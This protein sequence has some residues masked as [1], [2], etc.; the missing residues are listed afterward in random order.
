MPQ[1]VIP[2]DVPADV[3]V[4][5][6]VSDNERFV[7]PEP[8]IVD[9]APRA[10]HVAKRSATR[11]LFVGAVAA[12]ALFAAAFG[13]SLWGHRT[14][15]ADAAARTPPAPLIPKV[16][17]AAARKA[18]DSAV[19]TPRSISTD[20]TATTA[21]TF[22]DAAAPIPSAPR[23]Q[24]KATAA[25]AS[26]AANRAASTAPPVSRTRPL[27]HCRPESPPLQARGSDGRRSRKLRRTRLRSVATANP[28]TR[29]PRTS[30][31]S[32]SPA[33]GDGTGAAS[34][35]HPA[36]TVG[37][38]GRSS[39]LAPRPADPPPRSSRPSLRSLAEH[40]ERWRGGRPTT[41]SRPCSRR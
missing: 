20:A 18:A 15:P 3:V 17:V 14:A 19:S 39:V 24:P 35:S 21:L 40:F 36:P 33:D 29:P 6:V 32:V 30:R 1:A 41:G 27:P 12:V 23:I 8:V 13:G 9:P 34:H 10:T 16:E 26:R 28:S 31:I 5:P 2:I 37:R 38:S 25:T 4:V 11:R 7:S 22:A